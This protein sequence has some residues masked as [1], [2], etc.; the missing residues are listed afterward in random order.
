MAARLVI[1]ISTGFRHVGEHLKRSLTAA[2]LAPMY[3]F[4][5]SGP[6]TLTRRMPAAA[7]AAATMWVLPQPGG[8]YSSTPVR[9]LNGALP[10]PLHCSTSCAHPAMAGPYSRGRSE[11]NAAVAPWKIC[12]RHDAQLS[13][14]IHA[15]CDTPAAQLSTFQ[16]CNVYDAVLHLPAECIVGRRTSAT[17]LYIWFVMR[18]CSIR[19]ATTTS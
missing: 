16:V 10:Q 17:D 4:S 7:T 19:S 18:H 9:S 1:G 15:K 8:P 6:F 13:V 12:Q 2:S 14:T 11:N 3:L 5:T